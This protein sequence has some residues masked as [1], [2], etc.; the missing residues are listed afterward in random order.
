MSTESSYVR[1]FNGSTW[2]TVN[3]GAGTTYF[4]VAARSSGDMLVSSLYPTK[5]TMRF[6]SNK[7]TAIKATGATF[8]R[9][10]TASPNDV[11]AVGSSKVGRFNGSTWTVTAPLGAVSLF[12]VNGVA[13]H[14]WAVGENGFVAHYAY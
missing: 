3:P 2:S 14:V 1:K 13:G 8:Q 9:M 7:W 12:G 11:W 5:E 6:A 10:W 4:A